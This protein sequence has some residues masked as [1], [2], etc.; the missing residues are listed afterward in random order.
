MNFNLN[1]LVTK[2]K[3]WIDE[4]YTSDRSAS[5]IT[6]TVTNIKPL[7][8]EFPDIGELNENHL[9]CGSICRK[10]EVILPNSSLTESD[11]WTQ[12]ETSFDTITALG[13]PQ[14]GIANAQTGITLAATPTSTIVNAS[15]TAGTDG[16]EHDINAK[17]V[18]LWNGL[19]VGDTVL[20][21]RYMAGDMYYIADVLTRTNLSLADGEELI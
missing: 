9:V 18:I 4:T 10:Y 2:I 20:A 16:H 7:C 5:M 15:G 3:Q 13:T 8:V 12:T 14:F 19:Q 11:V 21:F 1:T 6:G 17:K